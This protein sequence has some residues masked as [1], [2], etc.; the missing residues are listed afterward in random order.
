M[1]HS[2]MNS[3]SPRIVISSGSTNFRCLVKQLFY[4]EHIPQT[5]VNILF[6]STLG[7]RLK[8]F[9]AL[10]A[11]ITN[12]CRDDDNFPCHS[13]LVT[14]FNNVIEKFSFVNA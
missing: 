12:Q 13:Q 4:F 8:I 5:A 2:V 6:D 9:E 3:F 1:R 11:V 7:R 14:H 10:S